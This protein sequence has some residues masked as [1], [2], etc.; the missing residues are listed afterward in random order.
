[1]TAPNI[2][3]L[4]RVL[5]EW[6]SVFNQLS[7]LHDKSAV[8]QPS[9]K[10]DW[11]NPDEDFL[12]VCWVVQHSVIDLR[13]FPSLEHLED[14]LTGRDYVKPTYTILKVPLFVYQLS[15]EKKYEIRPSAYDF[16]AEGDWGYDDG[17]R[18]KFTRENTR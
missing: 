1:M 2:G 4:S 7:E 17:L 13:T 18:R 6:Q 11:V 8:V 10:T 14:Y 16:V 5:E 3:F 15:T 9:Y 12:L